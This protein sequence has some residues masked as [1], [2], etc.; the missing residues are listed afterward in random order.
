MGVVQAFAL[1]ILKVQICELSIY[2]SYVNMIHTTLPGHCSNFSHSFFFGLCLFLQL[3]P[4]YRVGPLRLETTEKSF[5]RLSV[6][7]VWMDDEN[8][9]VTD[10]LPQF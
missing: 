9:F 4:L 6:Q 1:K 2:C 8:V 5:W 10:R 7:E 3:W